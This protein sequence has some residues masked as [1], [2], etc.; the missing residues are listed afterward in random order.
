MSHNHIHGHLRGDSAKKNIEIAFFLNL[1][2]AIIELIGGLITNSVAI[3]SD[4]VHDFG[5]SL[6][7]GVA[8]YLQKVSVKK[9]DN[10]FSYGYKRFSLLGSIFISVVL[11]VGSIFIVS[12]SVKRLASPQETDATGMVILAILGIVVNGAAV[13]RLKKGTSYNERAVMIHM[14]EDVLGWVAVLI[15]GILMHFW[16]A[17][18]IDPLLSILITIWVL[19]N[20]YR[21]L[22]STIAIML[23]QVPKD[24]DMEALKSDFSNIENVHSLHD[25]HVWSLD[26]ESHI[27]SLHLVMQENVS[28]EQVQQAKQR[29][30]ELANSKGIN[31]V[32]VEVEFIDEASRCTY[33]QNPC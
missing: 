3:L 12:E 32:T 22:S 9:G 10:K 5:D 2:F 11:V 1:I 31:H 28:R 23:Q 18:F 6:S 4:A 15:G 19:Y 8:W 7:L 27:M 20:V 14:M 30:K 25:L 16:D 17:T 21:N 26:G 24:V 33:Y 13:L 29:L